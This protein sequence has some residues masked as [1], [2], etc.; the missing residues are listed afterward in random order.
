MNPSVQ[1]KTAKMKIKGQA[2]CQLVMIFYSVQCKCVLFKFTI[3][4]KCH[5]RCWC[6]HSLAGVCSISSTQIKSYLKKMEKLPMQMSVELYS[7]NEVKRQ[8]G[9]WAGDGIG[10]W[11]T[12]TVSG[13]CINLYLGQRIAIHKPNSHKHTYTW[14]LASQH[15]HAITNHLNSCFF[16]SLELNFKLTNKSREEKEQANGKSLFSVE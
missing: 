1:I 13:I 2:N 3:P 5:Q 16:L 7:V 12:L 10:N 14:T 9:C 4:W 8:F 11:H 6:W 15:I